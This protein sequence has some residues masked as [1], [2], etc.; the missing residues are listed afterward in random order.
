MQ[1]FNVILLLTSAVFVHAQLFHQLSH[2]KEQES[3]VNLQQ[4]SQRR[5]GNQKAVLKKYTTAKSYL[6]NQT[7]DHFGRQQGVNGSWFYQHFYL[8]DDFYKTGGPVFLVIGAEAELKESDLESDNL[9]KQLAELHGGILVGLEHRF[10][11]ATRNGRSVPTVDLSN[12]SLQLLTSDQAIEDLAKF[13][14]SFPTLFPQYNLSAAGTKWI[15]IGGSYAGSLSAWLIQKHPDLVFAA[16]ASSAPVL[17]ESNFWRYSY[18]V[19]KGM[20]YF[21]GSDRC[22]QGWTRAVKAMDQTIMKLKSNATAL[23]SF[24]SKFWLS[25]V[26]N[27][28]DFGSIV[29]TL[30]PLTVQYS[31]F[32]NMF[33][34]STLGLKGVTFLEAVCGGVYF[35]AFTNPNATNVELLVTLQNYTI[36]Y[37][38]MNGVTGDSDPLVDSWNTFEIAD[39]NIQNNWYLWLHQVCNEFAYG[40]IAQ[41]VTE[42]GQLI[43]S[44]SVYSQFVTLEYYEWT[45]EALGLSPTGVADTV[46]TNRKYNGLNI[47]TPR[48]LWVN[49]DI[50]PWHWLSNFES[51]PNPQS[52]AVIL[53]ENATHCNDLWGSGYQ[54]TNYSLSVFDRILKVY[55]GWMQMPVSSPTTAVTSAPQLDE[56]V[57]NTKNTS[58]LKIALIASGVG[59]TLLAACLSVVWMKISKRRKN[60][61]K[62]RTRV[63]PIG[64]MIE[65]AVERSQQM[66]SQQIE[67]KIDVQVLEE[68]REE[69]EKSESKS[70]LRSNPISVMSYWFE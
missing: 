44:W 6:F 54:T 53:F 65:K 66:E 35:P 21:S 42:P 56:V 34:P 43:S 64:N 32:A 4:L 59:V 31:S 47:T 30:F 29:T 22:M 41:S 70:G 69:F 9:P 18:T 61:S 28:G 17:A 63:D 46:S 57:E 15:S 13:I 3:K 52:Q 62:N 16:H 23:Q 40:M 36:A 48:I 25:R 49:G 33:I 11:G 67:S 38:S 50:D 19:E 55:S 68:Q 1:W 58:S 45:C 10:Y 2:Q 51:A 39:R 12:E 26:K 24:K 20:N 5:K 37:L 27:L 8:V 7:V 60:Y 14:R